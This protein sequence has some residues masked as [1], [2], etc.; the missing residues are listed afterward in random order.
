MDD[1]DFN[2]GDC[3]LSDEQSDLEFGDIGGLHDLEK[4]DEAMA[5]RIL[6]QKGKK[7]SGATEKVEQAQVQLEWS[8][9][10]VECDDMKRFLPTVKYDNKESTYLRL[11][12]AGKSALQLFLLMFTVKFWETVVK[13]SNDYAEQS[14]NDLH[15]QRWELLLWICVLIMHSLRGSSRLRDLWRTDDVYYCPLMSKIGMSYE[16]WAMIRKYLHIA[17][18]VQ[19]EESRN[20]KYFKIRLM[21]TEVIL[22]SKL[23]APYAEKYSVDEMTMD[24]HGRTH[25][26]NRTP[27]KKVSEGFQCVALSTS[28]GYVIDMHFDHDEFVLTHPKLSLTCN[29]VL[30]LCSSLRKRPFDIKYATIFMD[31]RFSHPVMA[32]I[33]LKEM[34]LYSTGTWRINYGVPS[35]IKIT[36]SKKVKDIDAA[37]AQGVKLCSAKLNNVQVVGMSLYDNAPFYMLTTAHYEFKI[38]KGGTKKVDRYDIQHDYNAN[39]GGNDIADSLLIA[40]SSYVRSKKFWFR[41]FNFCLDL[42]LNQMY[43]LFREVY[44]IDH[45]EIKSTYEHQRFLTDFLTQMVDYCGIDRE[46]NSAKTPNKKQKTVTK[47]FTFPDRYHPDGHYPTHSTSK[48][49]KFCS[50][51][52]EENK[53]IFCCAKCN[54]NLCMVAER[55]CFRDFHALKSLPSK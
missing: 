34:Y 37:K 54:V 28:G 48:R 33:L 2:T 31:N 49:C 50:L 5:G 52:K 12:L 27:S 3:E 1:S 10:D 8:S 17:P 45:P 29:R 24:Y 15:L 6:P 11:G 35:L 7:T 42:G 36:T 51:N 43:L 18:V 47:D 39:M 22:N 14:G 16:R 46:E 19:P 13:N 44:G 41:L 9:K 23:Y 25:L 32:S 21:L 4:D 30:R 38:E 53:T 55:N 20:D 26:T 40:Y